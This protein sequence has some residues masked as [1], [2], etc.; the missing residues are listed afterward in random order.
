MS[1]GG[2]A[3]SLGDSGASGDAGAFNQAGAA[4]ASSDEPVPV[5]FRFMNSVINHDGPVYVCGYPVDGP[6]WLGPDPLWSA[7]FPDGIPHGAVTDYEPL[8]HAPSGATEFILLAI[9]SATSPGCPA[10]LETAQDDPRLLFL[11][12]A[13]VPL[14]THSNG[15]RHVFMQAGGYATADAATSFDVCGPNRDAPCDDT[16]GPFL[17]WLAEDDATPAAGTARVFVPLPSA[18]ESL[19]L[20]FAPDTGDPISLTIPVENYPPF[21]T[22]V[23]YVISDSDP[24][25]CEGEHLASLQLPAP[26]PFGTDDAPGTFSTI[27]AGD[28]VAFIISGAAG[29]VP[30]YAALSIV[31]LRFASR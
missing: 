13:N 23:V 17:S 2:Y 28:S 11:S 16:T 20:C 12:A 24:L 10:D 9:L 30:A 25:G 6:N 29:D 21:G 15:F 3:G 8:P 19:R 27:D 7:S 22:G 26:P 5:L 31:P 1:A 4:G 14:S 18:V